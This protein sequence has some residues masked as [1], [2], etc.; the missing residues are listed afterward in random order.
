ASFI[1]GGA[2][3]LLRRVCLLWSC[4]ASRRDRPFAADCAR[5]DRTVVA[6][7]R[8]VFKIKQGRPRERERPWVFSSWTLRGWDRSAGRR[9][10]PAATLSLPLAFRRFPPA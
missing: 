5:C 1:S 6:R 3:S 9:F 10:S 4:H 8:V 7:R 2:Y